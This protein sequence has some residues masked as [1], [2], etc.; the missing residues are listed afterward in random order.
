MVLLA[1][2]LCAATASLR[3]ELEFIGI[4][5]TSQT[6]R[7]AIADTST[8]R[9]DWRERG[10]SF[11][12]YIIVSY[13]PKE[14]TLLLRRDAQELR[15]RLKDDAKVK[16]ARLELTG[17]ITFGAIEKVEVER[18]TLQFDEENVFP[19]NDG[20]TYRITPTRLPDGNHRYRFSIE[21]VLA[22]NKTERVSSP[23]VTTLPGQPFSLQIGDLG[24]SFKPR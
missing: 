21:R 16:A 23:A 15:I 17:T 7:F 9:S 14:E 18:A 13:D 24:F 8:G 3:A 5:A 4:L 19:L 20:I 11:A 10:Q 1:A 2:L 12:G 6:T 22:P